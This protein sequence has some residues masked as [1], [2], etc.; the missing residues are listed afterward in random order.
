MKA[1][2]AYKEKE[3]RDNK[4]RAELKKKAEILEKQRKFQEAELKKKLAEKLAIE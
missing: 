1:M 4:E 3:E 2:K